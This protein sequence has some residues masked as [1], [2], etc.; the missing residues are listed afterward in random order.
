VVRALGA[1]PA[2][3]WLQLWRDALAPLPPTPGV[4]VRPVTS[5]EHATFAAVM[6]RGFSMPPDFGPL[7]RA[8]L[9]RPGW[10]HYL[11]WLDGQAVA[12]GS[13]YVRG[14]HGWLGNAAT[15]PEW[16]R[17]GAQAA[18]IARRVADAAGAGAHTVFTQV[19]QDLP[20]RPNPSEHNMR[21]AGFRTAYQRDHWILPTGLDR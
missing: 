4:E 11:A 21:R 8:V 16:R 2:R 3:A 14:G 20:D 10:T 1:R 12:C 13:L 18:L 15:L 9:G 6:L 19:A 5:D 17:R 7:A